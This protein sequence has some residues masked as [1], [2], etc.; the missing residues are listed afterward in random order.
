M[1]ETF[2]ALLIGIP[3]YKDPAIANLPFIENDLIELDQALRGV[4]Y[5]VNALATDNTDQSAVDTQIEDF[6]READP[7]STL[8][9][10]LSGHGVHSGGIDYLVPSGASTKSANFP[11]R[12][13]PISFDRYIEGSRARNIIVMIDACREGISLKEKGVNITSWSPS[14]S[15]RIRNQ[16]VA[17]L[18]ACSKGEYARYAGVEGAPQFSLFSR[19]L[20]EVLSQNR[21]QLTFSQISTDL[22]RKLYEIATDYGQPSQNTMVL[23]GMSE[24]DREALVLARKWQNRSSKVKGHEWK[25]VLRDRTSMRAG[26]RAV[27]FSPSGAILAAATHE[28]RIHVL[29]VSPHGLISLKFSIRYAHLPVA[30]S[31]LALSFSAD[32]KVLAVGGNDRRLKTYELRTGAPPMLSSNQSLHDASISALAFSPDGNLLVSGSH[33]CSAIVWNSEDPAYPTKIA[34]LCGH[35]GHINSVRFA[36]G[37]RMLATG[38]ADTSTMIWDLSDPDHPSQ[39]VVLKGHAAP[40]RAVAF[41]S[42]GTV[43]ATGDAEGGLIIWDLSDPSL[44]ARKSTIK[45]ATSLLAVDSHPY[46]EMFASGQSD[47]AVNIWDVADVAQPVLS[48][49]LSV[50]EGRIRGVCF[51]PDGKTLAS[52]GRDGNVFLWS[53]ER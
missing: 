45:C 2:K 9:I 29:S 17:Y 22:Q 1:A 24:Q 7:D 6:L 39:I 5:T 40:V 48:K 18:Y 33:D 4:N 23:T 44:P 53:V 36:P 20:I 38:S 19:A 11:S 27:C 15:E 52:G 10:F 8:L 41:N 47:G 42:D 28:P 34:V 37:T 13:V 21:G 32:S 3:N 46:L 16:R 14:Q 26:V 43:L 30:H 25:I 49:S 12:C 51:S 50:H 35:Q 31:P